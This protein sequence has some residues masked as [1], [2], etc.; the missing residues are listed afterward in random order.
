M[1]G[2]PAELSERDRRY[3]ERARV[4]ARKGWGHVQPNP[5]VGCVL[6]R[7]DR[8]VGE[9]HHALFGGP[10]AEIVALEQALSA[11][12]GATAYVSLEPCNHQGK[13]PPCA[14]A[15][16][17]A[18]V[19]R[20]VYGAAD[21]GARSGGGGEALKAAG[22]E[23]V[24][25]VWSRERARAENPAFMHVARHGTPYVALKLAMT[26]DARISEAPGIPT[27]ITGEEARRE[28]HR[29]RTGFDAV[30]VGAE[31]ARVDDPELTVR[32][33]PQGRRPARRLVLSPDAGLATDRALFRAMDEAPVHVFTRLDA[34]EGAIERLE[35]AGAHVHPVPHEEGLLDLGAVSDVSWELGIRSIFCEGG[36][37]LAASLLRERRVHRLYLFIA[38]R[39]LGAE[40]V[41]AFP[42]G[43]DLDWSDFDPAVAPAIFGRDTLL[44]LDRR[45]G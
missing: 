26:L 20:V 3:L 14:K 21:P 25:P 13:T 30:L 29:L 37:R 22:L 41:P 7:D 12:E 40:G 32:L 8:V 36:G 44:V 5:M 4:L 9:G 31:T 17:E 15:L 10:H 33:A 39:T 45:E 23:V 43:A 28:V 16:V 34:S 19:R 11:A 42:A 6:V 35:D 27:Q 2:E 38:P 18:G 24:G 1:S